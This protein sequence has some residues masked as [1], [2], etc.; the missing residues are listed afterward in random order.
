MSRFI[1]LHGF[2]S[3]PQS[4][5][6][7][8]FGE[9]LSEAGLR[10]ESPDLSAGD[11]LG[12]TI[13]GQLSVLERLAAGDPVTLIGSSLGGYLAALYAARHPETRRVLL[14]APAFGFNQRW[15]SMVGA[16]GFEQW[17]Q[18]G[19][20]S[21][22][23]YSAGRNCDLGFQIYEESQKWEPFPSFPQPAQIYHGRKDTVVFPEVSERYSATHPNTTVTLLDSDHELTDVLPEIW[24]R[25]APFLLSAT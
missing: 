25:A 11:F 14:L 8:F 20:L 10:L 17:R 6:A 24:Q 23:H 9:R 19:K 3:G 18:T 21:V 15:E 22:Y 1:Y 5:K 4:R 7:R 2:A 13:G 16:A 12:L